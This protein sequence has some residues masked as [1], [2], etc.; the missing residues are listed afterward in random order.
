MAINTPARFEYVRDDQRRRIFVVAHEPLLSDDLLAIIDRQLRENT[1][2]YG[3]LYDVRAIQQD[4]SKL[5]TRALAEYVRAQVAR[6]GPRGSLAIVTSV[7]ATMAVGQ[8]YGFYLGA[9][10]GFRV[11]VFHDA[12]EAE[13][14]LDQQLTPREPEPL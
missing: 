13:R 9:N 6:Y 2:A 4:T 11:E 5:E 8:T 10:I 12:A 7:P 14:W 3:M 1:W